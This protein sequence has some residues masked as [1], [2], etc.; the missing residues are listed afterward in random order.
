L[1][2]EEDEEAERR[3]AAFFAP[4]PT[5]EETA[6]SFAHLNLSRPIMKVRNTILSSDG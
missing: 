2:Q 5:E 1:K 3:K 6:V 4:D